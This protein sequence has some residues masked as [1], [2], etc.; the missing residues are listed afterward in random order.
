MIG[1]LRQ[2]AVGVFL[3]IVAALVLTG[4]LILSGCALDE[5]I[6]VRVPK[7]VRKAIKAPAQIALRDSEITFNEWAAYVDRGSQRFTRNIEDAQFV[8]NF[9]ASAVDTGLAFAEGP[10]ATVPGGAVIFGS[11][12]GAAGL[13]MRQPG[14]QKREQKEKESSFK[15]GQRT[16]TTILSNGHSGPPPNGHPAWPPTNN[17]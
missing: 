13:F 3:L 11:L 17:V 7:D 8:Y 12:T 14:A 1:W 4:L 2:S 6:K 10:L 5:M 15:A 9:A 16:A